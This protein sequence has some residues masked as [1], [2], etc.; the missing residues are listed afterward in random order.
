M[1]ASQISLACLASVPVQQKTHQ[2]SVL[3]VHVEPRL[4]LG[5]ALR[6]RPSTVPLT[7]LQSQSSEQTKF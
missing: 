4:A 2:T 5:A 7:C 6:P 3:G 1:F